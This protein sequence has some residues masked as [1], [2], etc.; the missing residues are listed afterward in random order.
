MAIIGISNALI[1]DSL[2]PKV[3]T[4]FYG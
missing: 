2:L 3:Q 4:T 1:G